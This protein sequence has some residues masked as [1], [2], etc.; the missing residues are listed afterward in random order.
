MGVTEWRGGLL[1]GVQHA[2]HLRA[3]R[4]EDDPDPQTVE[5]AGRHGNPTAHLTA[6]AVWAIDYDTLVRL[7]SETL[8]V[9]GAIRLQGATGGT[10]MFLGGLWV[11][12]G[13]QYVVVSRPG[14]GDIVFV[15]T[16]SL[17]VARVVPL[18]GQPLTAAVIG[19]E[20]VARDWKTGEL[21]VAALP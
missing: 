14:S 6:D 15:D 9:N 7:D 19:G 16:G 4:S 12:P 5:L 8:V 21:L 13:E 10:R 11:P 17:D 18:G 20:V 2:G 3:G 1:F